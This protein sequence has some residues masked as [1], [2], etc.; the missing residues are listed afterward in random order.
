[1]GYQLTNQSSTIKSLLKKINWDFNY[2]GTLSPEDIKPFDSRKFHWFPAT[3]IPEIPFSLIE[4]LTKEGA[5]VYDPFAGSGTTYF[6][7]IMLN[8]Q[9]ITSDSNSIS[10]Q[11]IKSLATLIREN[12][13]FNSLK[14]EVL[15]ILD[16][17]ISTTNYVTEHLSKQ[18]SFLE[19][20]FD[21]KT[22]NE[23]AF[24]Y[25][26]YINSKNSLLK[27]M[28]YVLLAGSIK[29]VCSQ[30]RGYGYIADNVKPKPEKIKYIS[31]L[32]HVRKKISTLIDEINM[33]NT[34]I[35]S[36]E[37]ANRIDIDK[38]IV[39]HNCSEKNFLPANSVDAI[40]TSPPYPNMIDYSKGQRL[41][42]YLFNIDF[43]D[44]LNKEIGARAF[45]SRKGSIEAYINQMKL[46]FNNLTNILKT[47]G[48]LC[49]VLPY[50]DQKN[51]S[52]Q[53][54][55]KEILDFFDSPKYIKEE[56]YIR[57]INQARK[58]QN[59]ALSSLDQELIVIYR[60]TS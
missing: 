53:N 27:A 2:K 52:R 4:I 32:S 47:N 1:M 48:L 18:S 41:L 40:I 46:V 17:Y 11:Y 51:S 44:D 7:A 56:E 39:Q 49:L 10:I 12:I 37:V 22:L 14:I 23:I 50:Y 6:Q 33:N 9:A 36:A 58:V 45:R 57:N 26:H 35:S 16:S 3:Y 8:R 24:I 55:I 38:C 54:A 30:D 21:S 13:K 60:K 29:N 15:T 42:Y 19:P 25:G 20:W 34:K 5:I 31:L 28:L 59:A 43:K